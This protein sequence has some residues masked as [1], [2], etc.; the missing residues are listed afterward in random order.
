MIIVN[1][2]EYKIFDAH[3]HFSNLIARPLK[4]ILKYLSIYEIIDLI[5]A[6]WKQIKGRTDSR[7]EKNVELFK[8]VLDYYHIDK[9]IN[10]PVFKLDR[11]L[12]YKMNKLYPEKMIGFGYINP[13]SRHLKEDLKELKQK[14][15]KGI[16]IHP[17]FMKFNFRKQKEELLDIFRYCANYKILVLSHTGSHSEIK[18]IIPLLKKSDETKFV[19]G[20]S[21]LCPQIQHALDV[22]RTCPNTFL[23]ISGNPYIFRFMEAIKDPDIGIEKLLFGSDLPSLNPRVEIQKILSLDI[24]KAERK[25]IFSENIK[26][27]LNE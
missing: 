2:E 27:I 20:H 22:A 15:V 11:S 16:K 10:L 14:G 25:L 23:E 13:R 12:S 3:T 4:F 8:L 26:R 19:I 18:N 17:D 21:G 5:F 6:N 9:A 7:K 1:D 24:S